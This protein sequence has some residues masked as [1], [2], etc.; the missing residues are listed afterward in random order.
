M[1]DHEDAIDA[2]G[3]LIDRHPEDAG[4]WLDLGRAEEASGDVGS[5][6]DHY[7]KAVELDPQYAAAHLR[8]GLAEGQTGEVDRALAAFD[9]AIRLYRAASRAEGEAEAWLGRGRKQSATG[10][11][12]AARESLGKALEISAD[13]RYLSQ[14]VRSRFQLARVTLAEGRFVDAMTIAAEAVEEATSAGADSFAAEG[15]VDL[16]QNLLLRRRYEDA[17]A[18]LER[19]ILLASNTGAR[20]TEA[21]ATDPMR[22]FSENGYRQLE[23]QA[24]NI[25]SRAYESLEQYEEARRLATEVLQ[26]A[27]SIGDDSLAGV[28]LENLAGVSTKLGRLPDA[29][30][31]RDRIERMHRDQGNHAYLSYDLPNR[32]ELLIELGRGAEAETLLEE[33]EQAGASGI[34]AYANRERRV[35]QLRMLR[36]ATEG[37]FDAVQS[38]ADEIVAERADTPDRYVRLAVVLLEYARAR[39]GRSRAAPEV[40][41]NWAQAPESSVERR[42]LSYWVARILVAR[43]E[44]VLALA[45][46]SDALAD[47]VTAGSRALRWRLEAIAEKA[48]HAGAQPISGVDLSARVSDDTQRLAAEWGGDATTYFARPDLAELRTSR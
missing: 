35:A 15:L 18:Q 41:T 6:R 42:T 8:F 39:V 2:L 48:V 17:D 10:D 1:R 9:E 34:A 16:A 32:A 4:L 23:A 31:H 21:L 22:F 25:L 33:V 7:A 36:A 14:R 26:Y 30:R 47:P 19:A 24:K 44:P 43:N 46:V 13:P 37:R 38:L 28:S 45:A 29:L 40:I 3:R 11:Y 20:R 12:V 5:A 27:E